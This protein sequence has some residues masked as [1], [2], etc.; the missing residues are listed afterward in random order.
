MR[1]KKEN[2]KE[3]LLQKSVS[4]GA[5]QGIPEMFFSFS[6]EQGQNEEKSKKINKKK[7]RKYF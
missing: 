3:N 4:V 6:K 5:S 1:K 2:S 7:V